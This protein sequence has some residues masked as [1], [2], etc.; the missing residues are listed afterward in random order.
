MLCVLCSARLQYVSYYYFQGIKPLSYYQLVNRCSMPS[1]HAIS[2]GR[3]KDFNLLWEIFS[4]N[5]KEKFQ[6][7]NFI[8]ISSRKAL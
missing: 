3:I 4:E 2:C 1:T 8:R 6:L 7:S 5:F